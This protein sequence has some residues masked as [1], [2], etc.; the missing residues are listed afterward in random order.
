[1]SSTRIEFAETVMTL[2]RR[3]TT[4]PSAARNTS[5]PFNRKAWRF[6]FAKV[7]VPKNFRSIGGGGGGPGGGVYTGGGGVFRTEATGLGISIGID[8]G[9]KMFLPLPEYTSDSV[10]SIGPIFSVGS[11]SV[12]AVPIFTAVPEDF[13]PFAGGAAGFVVTTG[14]ADGAGASDPINEV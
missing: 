12:D 3:C 9:E 4:S 13:A 7:A 14:A 8:A 6:P 11:S 1:M 10:A 2:Y 5:S